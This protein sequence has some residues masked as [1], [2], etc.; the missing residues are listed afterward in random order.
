MPLFVAKWPRS[1]R[2][3]RNG[4]N[5]RNSRNSRSHSDSRDSRDNSIRNII[6]GAKA[7]R[8]CGTAAAATLEVHTS[9]FR[10]AEFFDAANSVHKQ[11]DYMMDG[12]EVKIV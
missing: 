5:G 3:S 6:V 7:P 1:T 11:H 9:K 10:D 4:R 2:N 12:F 8:E